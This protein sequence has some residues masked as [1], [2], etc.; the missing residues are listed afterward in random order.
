MMELVSGSRWYSGSGSK[1]SCGVSVM[2]HVILMEV[3]RIG[4][5]VLQE[6]KEAAA[7]WRE[8]L[9]AGNRE[10][11]EEKGKEKG[12]KVTV[13]KDKRKPCARLPCADSAP[14]LV[15]EGDGLG[16]GRVSLEVA[17]ASRSR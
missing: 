4:G 6:A 11:K 7:P 2:L 16:S 3:G 15:E 5:E 10:E 9:A 1:S 13:D 12:K 14:D 17:L 8:P